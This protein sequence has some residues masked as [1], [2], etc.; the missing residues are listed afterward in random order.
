MAYSASFQNI[1]ISR[2]MWLTCMC[3]P[4]KVKGCQFTEIKKIKSVHIKTLISKL[5]HI[6]D[7]IINP[8]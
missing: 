5:F 7:P 2:Q 4:D 6:K 1:D 3:V 8:N